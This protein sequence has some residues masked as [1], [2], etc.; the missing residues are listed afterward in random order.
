MSA[1]RQPGEWRGL[2][3]A[4]KSLRVA[5]DFPQK[6]V[7]DRL[8]HEL[9]DRTLR[10]YESGAERPGRDRLL[11][12]LV[13]AFDLKHADEIN[14]HL[15]LAQYVNLRDE[16]IERL[17][18][19]GPVNRDAQRPDH[20]SLGVSTNLYRIGNQVA[21]AIRL[22]G[23]DSEFFS[24]EV[25]HV[26]IDPTPYQMPPEILVTR[27]AILDQLKREAKEHGRMFF[28]GPHTRLVDFR[29]TPRDATEQKH[30]ELTLGPVDWYDY[31]VANEVF[32]QTLRK[33]QVSDLGRFIDL[34]EVSDGRIK[35]VKL[36]NLL[37]IDVTIVTLDG[38]AL[39]AKRGNRVS[40][41]QGLLASAVAENMHRSFDQSLGPPRSGLLPVPFRT[42]IRGLEEEISPELV[43]SLNPRAL[44]LLGLAFNL[45]NLHPD[46]LFAAAVPFRRDEVFAMAEE[47]P[48]KDFIEATLLAVPAK[49]DATLEG[50]LS[51]GQW[52]AAGKACLIR[53]IEFLEA[54]QR[55]LGLPLNELIGRLARD[56]SDWLRTE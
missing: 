46:L 55:R 17:K 29:V 6:E 13:K 38:Y 30:L 44:V 36:S 20:V 18:L 3:E 26:E 49:L 9:S 4:L 11:R 25:V 19:A 56:G 39:Y 52:L 7:I 40:A 37:C 35:N 14:R 31:A 21:D 28:D 22:A 41:A 12:I 48:G 27:A 32:A 50:I 43:R 8:D 47:H 24:A 1:R 15:S 54:T 33:T 23:A 16:E 42:A 2:G 53:T 34:A 5:R 51:A 45:R 10:A